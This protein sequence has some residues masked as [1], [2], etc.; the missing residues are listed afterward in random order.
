MGTLDT[1]V[2]VAAS[3]ASGQKTA[4]DALLR[5]LD[6]LEQSYGEA[7]SVWQEYMRSKVQAPVTGS[8]WTILNWIGADRAHRLWAINRRINEHVGR[9]SELTGAELPWSFPTDEVMIDAADRELVNHPEESGSRAA[10]IAID[11]IN[12]RVEHVI[13]LRQELSSQ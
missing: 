9:I 3:W 5:Y 6:G 13:A 1:A 12:E 11:R 7:R 10:Q 2:K 8:R 4:R